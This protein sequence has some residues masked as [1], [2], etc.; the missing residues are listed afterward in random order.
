MAETAAAV[1]PTDS[2]RDVRTDA[3]HADLSRQCALDQI[4]PD[5]T[6]TFTLIAQAPA[7]GKPLAASRDGSL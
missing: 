1:R 7:A 6:V 5:L 3:R 4:R 2:W